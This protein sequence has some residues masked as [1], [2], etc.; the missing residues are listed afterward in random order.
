ME[1]KDPIV[2]Q[3]NDIVIIP[4]DIFLSIYCYIDNDNLRSISANSNNIIKRLENDENTDFIEYKKLITIS[5]GDKPIADTGRKNK[6]KSILN[7]LKKAFQYLIFVIFV[8]SAGV[9]FA[10]II[11]W[12]LGLIELIKHY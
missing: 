2:L 7:L 8:T 9:G 3:E 1:N 4:R 10:I 6:I 5:Y 12:A 11:L